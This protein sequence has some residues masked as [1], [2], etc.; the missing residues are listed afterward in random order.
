MDDTEIDDVADLA[1]RTG[2][3]ER[4]VLQEAGSAA[5]VAGR[6]VPPR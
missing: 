1:L 3:P 2:R 5:V 4:V 6:P